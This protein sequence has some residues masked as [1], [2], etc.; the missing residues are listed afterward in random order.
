MKWVLKKDNISKLIEFGKER[1]SSENY[2]FVTTKDMLEQTEMNLDTFCTKIQPKTIISGFEEEID[3]NLEK[4]IGMSK[5]RISKRALVIFSIKKELIDKETLQSFTSVDEK[6]LPIIQVVNSFDYEDPEITKRDL[7]WMVDKI[8]GK[9]IEFTDH[10]P[11]AFEITGTKQKEDMDDHYGYVK[12][13]PEIVNKDSGVGTRSPRIGIRGS[14]SD[15]L[16]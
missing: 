14:G 11:T 10:I 1:N 6:L 13:V 9:E 3:K 15:I 7:D 5:M 12:F 4:E 2:L 16:Y 8:H